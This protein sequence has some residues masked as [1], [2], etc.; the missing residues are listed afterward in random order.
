[1]DARKP[2]IAVAAAAA[3]AGCAHSTRTPDAAHLPL[4]PG[5]SVLVSVKECNRGANAYCS[6]EMVVEGSRYRSPKQLLFAQ[7]NYL[8]S[9]GWAP[10][11]PYTG[12]ELAAESPGHKLR[13]TY[14]TALQDLKGIDLG[15]IA[16][17][18]SITSALDKAVFNRVPTMSMV[19]EVGTQ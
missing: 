2:I 5:S 15:W 19:L 17:P 13:V 16:R 14:A 8:H 6:V 1:M 9:L 10:A 7:R 3:L 18:R 12:V 11:T 4:V